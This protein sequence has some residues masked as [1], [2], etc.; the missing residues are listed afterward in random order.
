M[1]DRFPEGGRRRSAA[2][3]V[4][5]LIGVFAAVL[6]VGAGCSSVKPYDSKVAEEGHSGVLWTRAHFYPKGAFNFERA[7]FATATRI[8]GS[9]NRFW[10]PQNLAP[11]KH[12]VEVRYDRQ[13]YLCGYLGCVETEQARRSFELIVEPGH[14]YMPFARRLCEQDWIGI[15]DT[16]RSARDD[17]ATWRSIGDWAF[18]DLKR[19]G[20]GSVVV[21]GDR[22][23]EHC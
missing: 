15:F 8:D 9:E 18:Q 17:I 3:R 7:T 14:S 11:G 21:A 4:A 13:S 12:S 6:F 5:G 10:R 1:T 2:I 16:G 19:L 23:P 22:P 20:P